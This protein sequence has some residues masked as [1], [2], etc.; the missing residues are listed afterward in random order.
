[1]AFD[2]LGKFEELVLLAAAALVGE[3][4]GVTIRD[5]VED[6]TGQRVSVGA[7]Y[8][9]LDRLERKGYVTSRLGEASAT[10]GG[11]RKRLHQVTARGTKALT[12]ART[13]RE[14]FWNVIEAAASP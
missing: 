6:G 1:M 3:G 9:T 8:A 10:R 4:Y 5:Y 14:H 2:R 12:E 11:K 7:V 13:V